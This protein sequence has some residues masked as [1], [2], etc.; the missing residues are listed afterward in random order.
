VATAAGPL[1]DVDTRLRPQGTQGMLAV[2]ASAFA[3]YQRS[4]A[5]TW[6]HMA[7]CRARPVV[8]SP[9]A[10]ASVAESISAILRLPR[11]ASRVAADAAKMRD[12]MAVHKAPA[13]PLDVKLG[14]G[15]L[16]DLE[17]AVHVLQLTRHV[18]LQ[19][20]LEDAVAEL[21]Q[22][23]LIDANIVEAQSLLTKML[24]V[25]R[26]LAPQTANPFPESRALMAELCGCESWD[27]LLGRHEAAR[28]CVAQVWAN[29]R[30]SQ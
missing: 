27:E 5:W 22:L 29:V 18:A 21:A 15:G 20:G 25:S 13:G 1:Y 7:L 24:V 10:R 9:S 3:D 6:E 12:E 14:P 30:N 19:P 28:Q 11:D 17:F 16:I 4:E 23:E 26:L 8:G 2:P